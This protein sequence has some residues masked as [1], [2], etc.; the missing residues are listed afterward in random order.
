MLTFGMMGYTYIKFFIYELIGT[1]LW[2]LTFTS[3]GFYFGNKAIEII[4]LIQ[5]NIVA[6]LFIIIIILILKKRK[7]S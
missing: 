7:K 2:A 1:F 4:L 6:T 5:K 3:I